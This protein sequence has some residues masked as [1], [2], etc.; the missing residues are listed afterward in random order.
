MNDK[1]L[2]NIPIPFEIK[3]TQEFQKVLE[4]VRSPDLNEREII[5][6]I[7]AVRNRLYKTKNFQESKGMELL[8]SYP[9]IENYQTYLDLIAVRKNPKSDFANVFYYEEVSA[10]FFAPSE[11]PFE[12]KIFLYHWARTDMLEEIWKSGIMPGLFTE[13]GGGKAILNYA[14][15]DA[16]N[17]W[18]VADIGG[19]MEND[20]GKFTLLQVDITDSELLSWV[21]FTNDTNEPIGRWKTQLFSSTALDPNGPAKMYNRFLKSDQDTIKKYPMPDRLNAAH[22][23]D[24]RYSQTFRDYIPGGFFNSSESQ[25]MMFW[26]AAPKRISIA[27]IPKPDLE[28]ESKYLHALE[29]G[30]DF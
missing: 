29:R 18:D 13:K 1:E 6:S 24:Y 30:K 7:K 17:G 12:G 9:L 21:F 28:K 16:N 11:D 25:E 3:Q 22:E 4:L 14:T 20:S 19:E 2:P 26:Y 8:A 27:Q 5:K 15:L 23:D 10:P